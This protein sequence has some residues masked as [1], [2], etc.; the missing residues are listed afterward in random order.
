[1][2]AAAWEEVTASLI[3]PLFFS[4]SRPFA[5]TV[6]SQE[7]LEVPSRGRSYSG[8]NGDPTCLSACTVFPP[9]VFLSYQGR[10]VDRVFVLSIYVRAPS[11]LDSWIFLYFCTQTY[12]GAV[13]ENFHVG[14]KECL[15]GGFFCMCRSTRSNHYGCG[16]E[17]CWKGYSFSSFSGT[18][19]LVGEYTSTCARSRSVRHESS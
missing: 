15:Y 19:V 5:R 12:I 17:R 4:S 16:R 13:N 1:M 11:H 3:W 9:P 10:T 14:I 8:E 6:P 18:S 7:Y 2:C